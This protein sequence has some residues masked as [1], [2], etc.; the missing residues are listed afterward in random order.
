MNAV[1]RLAAAAALACSLAGCVG[2]IDAGQA[3]ICRSVIPALNPSD[4]AFEIVRIAPLASGDGVRVE[5]RVAGTGRALAQSLPR[6]PVRRRQPCVA[7]SGRPARGDHGSRT[8][9]ASCGCNFSSASGWR[10]RERRPTPSRCPAPRCRRELP[11]ALAVGLQHAAVRAAADRHLCAAGGGLFAGLR[12]GR[13]HQPGLRRAGGRRA[14]TR[15]SSASRLP[16]AEVG[17]RGPSLLALV[18]ALVAGLAYG[19][20][21]RASRVRAADAADAGSGC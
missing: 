13:P 6:V 18:L 12:P 21:T 10:R 4:A 20:A 11:R 16:A 19:V 5:Y 9:R 14:A 3:R 15:R 17:R 2:G 1:P 8:A 7:R